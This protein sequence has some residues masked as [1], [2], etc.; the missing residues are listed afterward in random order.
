ML[1]D[2][3]AGQFFDPAKLHR[4][5]HSGE[6]FRVQGPMNMQRPPQG[7]PLICQAGASAEGTAFAAANGELLF[8]IANSVDRARDYYRTIKAAAADAGRDPDHVKVLVGLNPVIGATE[9][10]AQE[11]YEEMQSL[12]DENVTRTLAEHYFGI[13]LSAYALDEPVPE[14]DLPDVGNSMPRAHQEFMLNR[15]RDEGLTMRQLVNGFNG[16][17]I[18]PASAEAA[19]D[20]F[21]D[22]LLGDACDG[23][24]LQ[25]SHLPEGLEDFERLLAPELR[26]AGSSARSTGPGRCA[27]G[28]ASRVRATGSPQAPSRPSRAPRR[29]TGAV[30]RRRARGPARRPAAERSSCAARRSRRSARVRL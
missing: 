3:A 16:L 28:S 24:I 4:L 14:I 22:Y 23:F 15:A 2:K 5:D 25:I 30:R 19:A 11:K 7:H 10:E 17:N 1:R 9:A 29:P 13:D 6:Y 27:T 20:Q 8:T 12:L 21:E 26:R 18:Y